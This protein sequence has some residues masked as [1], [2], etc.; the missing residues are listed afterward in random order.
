VIDQ[1][2]EAVERWLSA[3]LDV[4]HIEFVTGNE[5]ATSAQSARK[6]RIE[7]ALL[8]VA[9]RSE[10]RDI[11]VSDVRDDDGRV[12]ARQRSLRFFDVDY[13][14]SVTGQARAA[15]VTLG[16]LLR[17]LVDVDTIAAEYLPESLGAIDVPIE[18]GLMPS[19]SPA[20]QCHA[21]L[22]GVGL[23]LRVLLPVRPSADSEIAPPATALHLDMSP[24][25]DFDGAGSPHADDDATRRFVSERS[26]TTVR[27]RESISPRSS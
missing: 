8:A 7:V 13:R 10:R 24:P 26:W 6:Q 18:V 22:G 4:E 15:H 2:D 17:A 1:M 19:S 9:E 11:D 3:M 23:D 14:V 20:Q 16:R 25:P 5:E 21:N 27:R 12:M